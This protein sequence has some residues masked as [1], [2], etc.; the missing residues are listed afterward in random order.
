MLGN[1]DQLDKFWS[2]QYKTTQELQ[3]LITSIVRAIVRN[4]KNDTGQ[5]T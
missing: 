2:N 5:F 4:F 3:A 1:F